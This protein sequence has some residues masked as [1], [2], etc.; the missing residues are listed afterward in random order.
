MKP[1]LFSC[2][3]S[4]VAKN[5]SLYGR[6]LFGPLPIDISLTVATV[7]R[8]SLLHSKAIF[9]IVSAEIEGATHEYAS[10]PGIQE[11]VLEI[12]L[13]LGEIVLTSAQRNFISPN[14]RTSI[15]TAGFYL[16]SI[17]V[18]GPCIVTAKD[19]HWP[20]GILCVKPD[21]YIA[22]LSSNETL[23]MRIKIACSLNKTPNS[24]SEKETKLPKPRTSLSTFAPLITNKISGA[25]APLASLPI[26]PAS[27]PFPLTSLAVNRTSEA[28]AKGTILD[29]KSRAELDPISESRQAIKGLNSGFATQNPFEFFKVQKSASTV[30]STEFSNTYITSSAHSLNSNSITI[31]KKNLTLAKQS[32]LESY[33]IRKKNLISLPFS[34]ITEKQITS[35]GNV[36]VPLKTKIISEEKKEDKIKNSVTFRVFPGLSNSFSNFLSAKQE[37][38]GTLHSSTALLSSAF[39]QAK[40]ENSSLDSLISSKKHVQSKARSSVSQEQQLHQPKPVT[41]T[42]SNNTIGQQNSLFTKEINAL[43]FNLLPKKNKQSVELAVSSSSYPVE[44]VNF[45]IE[46]DDELAGYR[47]RIIL[48]V[49]TNGSISPRQVIFES[50]GSIIK[51]IF[52]FREPLRNNLNSDFF[53]ASNVS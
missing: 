46:R 41:I 50:I 5:G 31:K 3:T 14:F 52:N 15:G 25:L 6:F 37:S 28:N 18:S 13:N 16:A 43:N 10:L 24:L 20:K 38:V 35:L 23:A 34:S 19:I 33:S 30:A 49:W 1:P 32:F 12:L 51:L 4:R 45:L 42:K 17:K 9:T 40:K 29:P 8:R 22:T 39:P 47:H 27:E 53:S 21:A 2:L 7:L 26:S 44:K 11:S 36:L 48:E